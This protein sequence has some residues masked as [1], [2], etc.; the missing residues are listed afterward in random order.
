MRAIVRLGLLPAAGAVLAHI[1]AAPARE[2]AQEDGRDGGLAFVL[3]SFIAAVVIGLVAYLLAVRR[4]TSRARGFRW[5]LSS[6]ALTVVFSAI[7]AIL[8]V[9]LCDGCVR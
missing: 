7:P 3:P 1:A 6:S 2:A 9:A 5:A 4:G 8:F